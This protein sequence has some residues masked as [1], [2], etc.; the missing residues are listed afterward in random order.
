MIRMRSHSSH[1]PDQAPEKETD[2]QEG[3]NGLEEEEGEGN[4]DGN[5]QGCRMWATV[6][7]E[8]IT[9]VEEA[10]TEVDVVD[11]EG[12]MVEEEATEGRTEEMD[13]KVE[14]RWTSST[15]SI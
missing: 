8:V 2:R 9:V 15:S 12:N 4:K 6:L 13:H 7:G 11:T 5:H 14:G 10:I 1:L 3:I